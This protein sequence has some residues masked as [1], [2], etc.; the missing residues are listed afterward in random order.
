VTERNHP[1]R[2]DPAVRSAWITTVGTISA[3]AIAA[4]TAFATGLVQ[5]GPTVSGTSSTTTVTR[6]VTVHAKTPDTAIASQRPPAPGTFEV[7]RQ[8]G[9]NA[10]TLSHGYNLDMDATTPDWDVGTGQYDPRFD[11]E[12]DGSS[13]ST[14]DAVLMTGTVDAD[15]CAVATGYQKTIDSSLL[16]PGVAMCL[17]TSDRRL[18]AL[19][20]VKMD[21][22]VRQ[23]VTFD[24]T[25]W[26]PPTRS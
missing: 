25:V 2:S 12:F 21:P 18:A 8:S 14:D 26:D 7:R 19:K 3:A 13:L 20:V 10:V 6:T 16:K 1:T 11:L 23:S 15:A 5:P 22:D 4:F 9:T 24:L 17:R